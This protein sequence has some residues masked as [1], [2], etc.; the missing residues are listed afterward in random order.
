[1]RG[2]PSTTT[3]VGILRVWWIV[4]IEFR[5]WQPCGTRSWTGVIE[6]PST[7]ASPAAV[8]CEAMEN[9]PAS[10]HA[11]QSSAIGVSGNPGRP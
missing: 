5:W 7:R 4:A 2:R 6:N 8:R 3:G 1:V 10:S 11:R 9:G